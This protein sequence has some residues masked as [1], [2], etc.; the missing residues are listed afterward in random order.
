[1]NEQ[2]PSADPTASAAYDDERQKY[3]DDLNRIWNERKAERQRSAASLAARKEAL[4][5]SLQPAPQSSADPYAG[6]GG[7][8]AK[9]LRSLGET[10]KAQEQR[11]AEATPEP[12]KPA[13]PDEPAEGQ[14]LCMFPQWGDDRRV[15]TTAVFRS[16]LF[17]VLNPKQP[18]CYYTELTRLCSV[19]GVDVFFMG[20]QFS[21]S[22]LDVYLE[23]LNIAHETPFGIEC[24]F[25]AYSLLKALGRADGAEQYKQLHSELIRLCAG[26]VDMTDHK[27]RYFGHL[28]DGGIKDEITSHYKIGINPRMA[29]LFKAGLWA[30]LDIQQRRD[31]KRNQTAKGLHAY[32]SSHAD[33]GP[34]RYETLAG[35]LGLKNSKERDRKATIIK[36]HE[37]LKQVGFLADY[38]A[39]S[40]TIAPKVNHT[41]SQIRHIVKRRAWKKKLP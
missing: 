4:E 14:Q 35:I 2:P 27:V 25:S 31:L 8:L 37:A 40:R 30:S 11:E 26:T 17:P 32:Y 33:P 22:D 34:H 6:I 7:E 29:A 15:T 19:D 10:M 38:E 39:G 36:G 28:V 23:L 21:Q 18:R 3:I 5:T 41:T 16:A 12:P 20:Q 24:C 1:M 9:S 13:A